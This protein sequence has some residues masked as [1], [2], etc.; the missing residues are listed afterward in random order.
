MNKVLL[1]IPAYNEAENIERVVDNI[2]ENFPQ[3]DYIVVNDGSSD[4]TRNVCRKRGYQYLNLSINLGIGGAV[5]TGYKYAQDKGYEI[6]VQIDGDG[7]HD[8]AYL[9]KMLPYL[10]SGEADVVIGSRFIEK[11]GFQSS[12]TRRTGIKILSFMIWL[13][14]GCKVKDVTSGFRAVNKRFIDIYSVNYP[15]DYPEPEAIVSAVM[16][17]GVV[18]ECPVVMRDRE[19]GTS[20]INFMKSIYYMI[21]VTLAI[22]VCRISFGVRRDPS[23]YKKK[24]H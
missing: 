11:E 15:M 23:F 8:I 9:E 4:E 2:I 18:K 16:H 10:E 21:K 3:Y 14:T 24:P 19:K 5:Q 6:A 12:A 22:I 1:I 20:S 7:Q 17:G 13:C